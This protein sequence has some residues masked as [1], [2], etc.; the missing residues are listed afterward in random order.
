MLS[1]IPD[2]IRLSGDEDGGVSL[3]CY[4]ADCDPYHHGDVAYYGGSGRQT[5]KP[6]FASLATGGFLAF[7]RMH[8]EMHAPDDGAP[9]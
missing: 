8:A 2:F 3:I 7:V 9:C 1:D 4:H 6:Y 5:G